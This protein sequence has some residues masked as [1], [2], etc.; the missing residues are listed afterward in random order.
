LQ[1]TGGLGFIGGNVV[2]QLL[3]RGVKVRAV[4][5]PGRKGAVYTTFPGISE[6]RLDAIEIPDLVNG[7][8]TPAFKDVDGIIHLAVPNFDKGATN[9]ENFE[10]SLGRYSIF[11]RGSVLCC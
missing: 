3:E 10:V 7:D 1:V 11:V 8:F 2:L 6:D 9:T 5:R 4:V